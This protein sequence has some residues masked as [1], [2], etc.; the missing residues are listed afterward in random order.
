[1]LAHCILHPA[2]L[3]HL[4]ACSEQYPVVEARLAVVGDETGSVRTAATTLRDLRHAIEDQHQAALVKPPLAELEGVRD[5]ALAAM[6][7]E[8]R[9]YGLDAQVR[10]WATHW[11]AGWA[12][13]AQLGWLLAA[14]VACS[15]GNQPAE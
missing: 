9:R 13:L 11:I 1:M 2:T 7:E 15:T 8:M 10:G 14:V 5:R 12:R 4:R 3:P 6:E